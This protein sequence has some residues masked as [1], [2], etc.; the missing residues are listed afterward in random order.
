LGH[1]GKDDLEAM[2]VA[3]VLAKHYKHVSIVLGGYLGSSQ[4]CLETAPH[5]QRVF[6]CSS[7]WFNAWHDTVVL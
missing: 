3:K 5:L 4:S 6:V 2:V 1:D 7:D